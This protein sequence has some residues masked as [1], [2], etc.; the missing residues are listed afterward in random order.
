MGELNQLNRKALI[1]ATLSASVALAALAVILWVVPRGGVGT[2]TSFDWKSDWAVEKGFDISIDSEG[3]RFPTA[4]AFVPNPGISP[5]DPLYFITELSGRIRV[6]TNDRS[7]FTFAEDFFSRRPKRMVPQLDE[8]SGM[9]GVCLAPAHGFVFVTFSYHDSDN[10]LRNNIVRF[11]SEPESFSLSPES[12]IDFTEIFDSYRTIPSHQ[13]GACRVRD[14][15]LYVSVADGGQ[16]AQSQSLDSVLGKILRMTLDGKPAPENPF[17]VDDDIKNSRNYVWAYGL[18]NPFGL[19]IQ[20]KN[21]FV[22]DNG[23]DIDRFLMVTE[24]TNYLW[25]GTNASI[26]TN[27]D[28]VFSPGRGVAHL[29]HYPPGSDLFPSRFEGN[30][31]VTMTGNPLIRR[32]GFPAIWTVPYDSDGAKLTAVARPISRFRGGQVQVISAI[33][34]GPDG[35]YFAPLLP[36]QDGFNGVYKI[37]FEPSSAYPFTLG[38][39]SNPAVLIRTQG[40]LAC[41][42]LNENQT[43]VVGPP[44]DRAP[45]TQSIVSRLNS[46]EYQ[47]NI[48]KID[49][50]EQEPFSSFRSARHEIMQANGTEQLK[51]WVY[52]RI[53]EPSFDDP[54]AT[55]PQLGISEPQANAIAEYL[56][57]KSNIQ[58]NNTT[59]A[60][61]GSSI[62][63]W[64]SDAVSNVSDW[65]QDRLPI[66]TR[67]NAKKY[68]AASLGIGLVL[69]MFA[70]VSVYL[71]MARWRIIKEQ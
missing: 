41:H 19:E 39:E 42:S 50:L 38:D 35:L 7:V 3:L 34:F 53:L 68:I 58:S 66:P 67:A 22:A 56:I 55:M 33:S 54:T 10:V 64:A 23:P 21:I 6:V 14:D 32:E 45:L 61:E 4:I 26:G 47:S 17:Y 28:A 5:K 63:G 37:A 62:F 48:E 24:G 40:C 30:V 65:V 70:S 46:P 69:G 31:F 51:K 20:G 13:I 16:L 71:I 8:E 18:R 27:A 12:M 29:D 60:G 25:D 11:Q 9:A 2:S 59:P 44:L 36:N 49:L 15:M 52:Y 43:G 1:R 57:G